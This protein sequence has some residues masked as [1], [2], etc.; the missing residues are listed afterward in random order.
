[1]KEAAQPGGCAYDFRLGPNNSC[2]KFDKEDLGRQAAFL[3]DDPDDPGSF[4]TPT[5]SDE[6]PL[7]GD[8]FCTGPS[9][10]A[11][12]Y[13]RCSSLPAAR[14]IGRSLITLLLQC[15]DNVPDCDTR[16]LSREPP[17]S[18]KN[19]CKLFASCTWLFIPLIHSRFYSRFYSIYSLTVTGTACSLARLTQ[20]K[21]MNCCGRGDDDI[22]RSGPKR[23]FFLTGGGTYNGIDYWS[24]ARRFIAPMLPHPLPRA[25]G[26]YLFG[27]LAWIYSSTIFR[28]SCF[29]SVSLEPSPPS[30][31]R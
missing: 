25:G 10:D 14:L 27:S 4:Y 7:E 11:P 26:E 22:F 21:N 16:F 28:A 23:G 29:S 8:C 1:M 18:L 12:A 6:F 9:S 20:R 24:E 19:F 13:V 3:P 31:A 30:G 17:L 5:C 2:P 15:P